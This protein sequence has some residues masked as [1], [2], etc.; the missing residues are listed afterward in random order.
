MDDKPLPSLER[1]GER[2][3]KARHPDTPEKNAPATKTDASLA[4]RL[5]IE[6]VSSVLVGGGMGYLLDQWLG[7]KP[8]LFLICFCLGTAAG[9]RTM[10][11]TA[12]AGTETENPKPPPGHK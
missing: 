11:R 2:I 6:M 12:I 5:G 3:E 1:L 7:T 4:M 9:I 8:W 10:Y